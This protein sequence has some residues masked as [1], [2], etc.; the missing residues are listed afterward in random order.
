MPFCHLQQ[1]FPNTLVEITV[2]ISNYYG[3][4]SRLS[5]PPQMFRLFLRLS[6]PVL[7]TVRFHPFLLLVPVK[8][9]LANVTDKTQPRC[10]PT[11]ALVT[12]RKMGALHDSVRKLCYADLQTTSVVSDSISYWRRALS[13]AASFSSTVACRCHSRFVRA[14]PFAKEPLQ[15]LAEGQLLQDPGYPAGPSPRLCCYAD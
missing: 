9:L 3:M 4:H 2:P 11:A 6:C 13:S 5:Y 12:C 7:I 15:L 10:L 1:G 8:Q 14:C